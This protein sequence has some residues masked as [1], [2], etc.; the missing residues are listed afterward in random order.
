M[1][2]TKPEC[3]VP[4]LVF[5]ENGNATLNRW[6]GVSW[7]G[8]WPSLGGTAIILDG[9]GKSLMAPSVHHPRALTLTTV[10]SRFQWHHLA[11]RGG[12]SHSYLF[13]T[14][15][16]LTPSSN[17]QAILII[18]RQTF[19]SSVCMFSNSLKKFWCEWL[20]SFAIQLFVGFTC[21]YWNGCPCSV[22][23]L[24]RIW[25]GIWAPPPIE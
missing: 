12:Y 18:R 13:S 4:S 21:N 6:M 16:V 3:F 1:S 11:A 8:Q 2:S 15:T 25:A 7:L 24:T 17:I 19:C 20:F 23:R 22:R 5:G 14:E 9:D 10:L